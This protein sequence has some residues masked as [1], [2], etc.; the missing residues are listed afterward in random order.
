MKEYC[1]M[2]ISTIRVSAAFMS[3]TSSNKH[4]KYLNP[5]NRNHK[6]TQ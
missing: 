4:E 5:N 1:F 2:V 3:M 6:A